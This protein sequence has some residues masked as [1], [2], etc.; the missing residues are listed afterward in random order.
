[1][2]TGIKLREQKYSQDINRV[3][4]GYTGLTKFIF[5]DKYMG[6]TL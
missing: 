2:I 5:V 3:D 4:T 1:M 6:F